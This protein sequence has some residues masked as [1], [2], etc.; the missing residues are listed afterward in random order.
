VTGAASPDSAS[1]PERRAA[2]RAIAR[3]AG[4]LIAARLLAQGLRAV[5]LV[6]L[7]RL[8][9]PELFALVSYAQFWQLMLFAV[10]VFGT[11]RL[12]S[13]EI[14]R[15]PNGF[16]ETL[17][18]SLTLR[19]LIALVVAPAA[20]AAGWWLAPEPAARQLLVV[21]SL[22]LAAR[23]IASWVHQVCIAHGV[24]RYIL[25]QEAVWR[26][27]E[28]LAGL[29]ALGLGAGLAGVAAAH[30]LSWSLQAVT[31]LVLV[32]RRLHPV[33]L[34]WQTARVRMLLHD[35]LSAML[36]AAALALIVN[37]SLVL[38]LSLFPDRGDGGQLA[39]VLQALSPLLLVPKSL[40]VSTLPVLGRQVVAGSADAARTT[41]MLL[42]LTLLVSAAV[43]L[44]GT[45]LAPPLT[46][47]LLGADYARA[48]A[49]FGPALWLLLPFG[50][51][52]LLT[53]LLF[54]RGDVWPNAARAWAGALVTLLALW[55][56][57]RWLGGAGVLVAMGLG[58]AVWTLALARL[59][60]RHGDLGPEPGLAA[61]T[62]AR[63]R[64]RQDRGCCRR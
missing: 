19:L 12:L 5:Y 27:V 42:R 52:Q 31:G 59:A 18:S 64:W 63:G 21:F 37:G 3:N 41:T 40:A 38:Y 54:A 51:G 32:H 15:D 55:P 9:G 50:A 6:A 22:A 45:V 43:A 13:R 25:R 48:G 60:Y 2:N 4:H 46:G 33:A 44:L 24:S 61:T 53:Q 16:A 1:A 57:A 23:A 10:V 39:V 56:L 47:L 26:S 30:A 20:A 8:L 62:E 28:V 34:G 17:T 7:A 35:G 11:G 14:G 58:L 29:T 36:A 49:W